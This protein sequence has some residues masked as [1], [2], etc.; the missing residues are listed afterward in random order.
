V[1]DETHHG[2]EEAPGVAF[3][4]R[5]H[6][7][8]WLL[9]NLMALGLLFVWRSACTLAPPAP[10]T[11]AAETAVGKDSAAGLANLLRRHVPVKGLL[12]ACAAEWKR[13]AGPLRGDRAVVANRVAAMAE[14]G[15]R[16]GGEAEGVVETYNRIG[17]M[18]KSE[19]SGRKTE[20]R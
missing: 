4:L 6:R 18:L 8:G 20:D 10:A 3:L 1:F 13:T 15:L 2:L 19:N 7:L 12:A 14:A 11:E 5:K 9:L 17:R 16:T